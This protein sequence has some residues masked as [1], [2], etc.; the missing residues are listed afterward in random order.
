MTTVK[1]FIKN[2]NSSGF[3]LIELLVSLTILSIVLT[4]GIGLILTSNASVRQSRSQR[5][6]I[7]NMT[8]AIESMSRAITY[9]N[10]FGC[11]SSSSTSNCDIY[12]TPPGTPSLYFQ[13]SYLGNVVDISYEKKI[14]FNTG[15]GYIA[16]TI[17][18]GDSVS[19][20]DTKI[21][22]KDLTFFVSHTDAWSLD[23]QQPRV[24]VVIRG[25]SYAKDIPE[26]F[27]IQT[28][29]SQRDLKL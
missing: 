9:G 25:F 20:T 6:V 27:F 14:D 3:T 18:G 12:S 7:D 23:H 19:L 16:R 13:G 17:N 28:T 24:T 4:I 5:K 8:F 10:H 2:K 11:Y 26:E 21:D 29:L 15:Y 22:I 1:S